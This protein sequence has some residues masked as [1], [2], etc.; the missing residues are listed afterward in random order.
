MLY[1]DS[2]IV[3]LADI[4]ALFDTDLGPFCIGACE[5]MGMKPLLDEDLP[6]DSVVGAMPYREYFSNHLG[7][8]EENQKRY[9]NSGVMLM[10]LS[11]LR[12]GK[13]EDK[14]ISF[15]KDHDGRFCFADQDVLNHFFPD[16]YLSLNLSWNMQIYD[17]KW[18]ERLPDETN[19]KFKTAYEAPHIVHF[20]I[21]DNKPWL[22]PDT[23]FAHRYREYF[24]KTPWH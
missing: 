8:N 11:K 19:R 2:D 4:A 16:N 14:F 12:E 18:A 7:L 9:F 1:L 20:T 10:D 22:F 13:Y 6:T 3:V 24:G 15:L 21:I 17:L 23:D 5:D